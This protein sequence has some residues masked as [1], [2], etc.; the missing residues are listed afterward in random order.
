MRTALVGSLLLLAIS[1]AEAPPPPP[2]LAKIENHLERVIESGRDR[3]GEQETALWL[4]SVDIRQG[5]QFE[6]PPKASRRTYRTIHA[7]HGSTLYWDQPLVAFAMTLSDR[8]GDPAYRAAA[9]EYIRDFLACCV[10]DEH[11]G[12][13]EWGN[14]LYY[15]VFTDSL[16]DIFE[17]IHEI[18]PM[19]PAWAM[20][21]TIDPAATE[22]EIRAAVAGHV[23][24]AETGLFNRHALTG[25]QAA[26]P[27]KGEPMPF[28]AAGGSLVESLAWLASQGGGDAEE[29]IERAL[30]IARYSFDK[31]DAATGLVPTQPVVQRWDSR[32]ATTETGLWAGAL[33]RSANLTGRQEFV[34]MAGAAVAAY[35]ETAWD[36]EAQ[37]YYGML[38][39]ADGTPES[40]RTT[41]W[42]PSLYSDVWEPLFPSH[43]YPLA[44][45]E[46]C[47]ALWEIDGDERF[48][49]CA[50]RWIEQIR[51]QMPPRYPRGSITDAESQRGTFAENYGRVIHFLVRAART[52]DESAALELASEVAGDAIEMLWVEE[53]GM[54]RSHP[55]DDRADAV[56]GLGYLFAAL[57]YLETGEEWNLGGMSF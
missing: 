10:D 55:G 47:L 51:G 32:V 21:W 27:P 25:P 38:R 7:P 6:P 35:L 17:P 53:V 34:E 24:D 46:T 14:H 19:T 1:C 52:L 9:E 33:L 26:E 40:E 18:R 2:Y 23:L 20:F 22:R 56:D 16:A 8:A 54:F 44:F 13:F 36:A 42:Q 41:E 28:L 49:T 29:L 4:A 57:A 45:A 15:D 30:T 50:R 3:Y 31:R 37:R 48:A 11:T 39:I 12:M 43:D 5:G